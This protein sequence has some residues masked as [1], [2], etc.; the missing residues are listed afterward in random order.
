M[1]VFPRIWQI[2]F[3]TIFL[4]LNSCGGGGGSGNT[5]GDNSGT[6]GGGT[7]TV[8]TTAVDAQAVSLAAQI[9]AG[10]DA[11]QPALTQA[12]LAAGFAIQAS[13]GSM[14]QPTQSPSQG[15][16]FTDW[17]IYVMSAE[18]NSNGYYNL[19]ELGSALQATLP[20]LDATL[21]TQD[22]LAGISQSAQSTQLTVR[23]WARLIVELGRQSTFAYDLLDPAVDPTQVYLSPIQ[24]NLLLQRFSGDLVAF[25][26]TYSI[27]P[28]IALNKMPVT[29]QTSLT[30]LDNNSPPPCSLT[31]TQ[32]KIMDGAAT[33]MTKGFEQ[34]WE[35]LKD[36]EMET[37]EKLGEIS[38]AVNNIAIYLKLAW[39]I[40]AFD[41]G[42]LWNGLSDPVGPLN[43]TP[44]A[45]PGEQATITVGV[46]L[47]IK[48]AQ[49][50]NCL[51]LAGNAIGLDFS[52]WNDGPIKNAGIIW[53]IEQG[54]ASGTS[55]GY[56]EWGPGENPYLGRFTDDNGEN[57]IV[58]MGAHRSQDITNPVEVDKP[59]RV[60]VQ[61]SLKSADL[62]QDLIDAAAATG[63]GWTSIPAEMIYRTG[64][65]FTRNLPFTVIDWDECDTSN[66]KTA[67]LSPQ[68]A[69]VCSD[70]W[71]G[72]AS[73]ALGSTPENTYT[74]SANVTWVLSEIVD[75]VSHYT[76]T[77]TAS[78][79]VPNCIAT[80]GSQTIQAN[81]GELAIDF[82]VYPPTYQVSGGTVW[83]ATYSCTNGAAPPVGAGGIWLID[84]ST[85][86]AASGTVSIDNATHKMIFTGN[87]SGNGAS[88]TWNFSKD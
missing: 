23:L 6:G 28:A 76:P 32:G 45:A 10:G 74:T 22:I 34:F 12:V 82:S 58:I 30:P 7:G 27:A 5:G 88:A 67:G 79:T 65:L 36:K 15:M 40:Y 2:L 61:V 56:L 75:G 59:G 87:G 21:I 81:E 53:H 63:T 46:D 33:G 68:A 55:I 64:L 44:P 52:L 70:T 13:D 49:I 39:T 73:F 24:L 42:F 86:T 50:L 4:G 8:D 69:G 85:F 1:K 72:M 37:A 25:V 16:L 71:T 35:Y 66:S 80:P 14:T 31:E 57:K 78:Y 19:N 18:E 84:P 38:G 11:V 20:S 54:G 83:S 60:S 9:L 29:Q 3:I 17:D 43:R 48:D 77:G 62:I 47:H 51:R 26:N 41:G